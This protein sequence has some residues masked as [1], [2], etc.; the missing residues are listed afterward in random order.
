M[1]SGQF[2]RFFRRRRKFE[3]NVQKY[4][5]DILLLALP[6]VIVMVMVIVI[7]MDGNGEGDGLWDGDGSRIFFVKPRGKHRSLEHVTWRSAVSQKALRHG[8]RSL[9]PAW[10]RPSPSSAPRRLHRLAW[11]A[12][13][14]AYS[15]RKIKRKIR[16]R[17]TLSF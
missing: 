3:N 10:R 2:F 8:K 14:H 1:G 11:D 16:V 9:E 13:A 7:A 15:S 6:M 5:A 4:V 17:E 12:L